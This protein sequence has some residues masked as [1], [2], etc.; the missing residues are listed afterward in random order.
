MAE[1]GMIIPHDTIFPEASFVS[2]TAS[3]RTSIVKITLIL[4]YDPET[5][6]TKE[7]AAMETGLPSCVA[8]QP[9]PDLPA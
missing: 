1:M 4:T 3:P 2:A 6:H 8:V 7:H 9:A 5:Q